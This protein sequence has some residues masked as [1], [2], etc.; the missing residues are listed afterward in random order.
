MS[1]SSS[2][3]IEPRTD[4]LAALRNKFYNATIIDRRL[5]HSDLIRIRIKPDEEIRHFDAGQYVALGLGRWESRLEDCQ[6]ETL[7]DKD[8]L[9]VARRA[10]SISCSMWE[11]NR[12]VSPSKSGYLEFYIVLVRKAS[13]PDGTPPLFTPR[14]F[15]LQVGDRIEVQKKIVGHYTLAG[16]GPDEN[17]LMIGT[18]TGEA[19]HN[20]MT[21]TLLE[22]AHRGMIVNVTTVRQSSDLGY[23]DEHRLLEQ[24]FPNYRYLSLTTRDPINLDPSIPGYVGKRY[25]QD[26]YT[27]G[28][29]SEQAGVELN[30]RNT[31]VFL[32]GNP[33]MIGYVKPGDLPPTTPGMLSVLSARGFTDPSHVEGHHVEPK[34]G[35]IRFEKYW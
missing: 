8:A 4:D 13:E 26:A 33:A 3:Q 14:L 31:H 21:A 29:L 24:E 35:V 17:V 15:R 12:I 2:N 22:R 20:S 28:W 11:N 5:V 18:G 10:Y 7:G 23:L 16:V 30:P 34:A 1:G 19:P 9:K 25:I 6:P 32:C 27:S